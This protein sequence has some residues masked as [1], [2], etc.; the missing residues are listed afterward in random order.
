M[1]KSFV[2]EFHSE[3]LEIVPERIRCLRSPFGEIIF[4]SVQSCVHDKP[5]TAL[6]ENRANE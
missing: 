1:E 4:G 6:L 5:I 3:D 2:W